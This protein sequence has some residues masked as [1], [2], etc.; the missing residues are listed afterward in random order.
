MMRKSKIGSVSG[1]G[2]G[3]GVKLAIEAAREGAK[4][5]VVSA[6]SPDKLD[7]AEARI[8][9]LGGK[10][11]VLKQL[12]D[13]TRREQCDALVAAA[14]KRFGRNGRQSVVEGKSVSVSGDIGGRRC[15]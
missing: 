2:P 4:G 15:I 14:V 5:V 7:D 10:T 9:A 13:V 8:K 12:C 6:R 1:I 11:D 3:L